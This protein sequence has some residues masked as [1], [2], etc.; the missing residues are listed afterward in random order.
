MMN[1]EMD[2]EKLEDLQK[3]NGAISELS[4]II[5]EQKKR[6]ESGSAILGVAVL[7]ILAKAR[8]SLIGIR[9]LIEQKEQFLADI[10][11][12]VTDKIRQNSSLLSYINQKQARQTRYYGYIGIVGTLLS[13]L[14]LSFYFYESLFSVF[15]VKDTV[16]LNNISN[17]SGKCVETKI[18]SAN[19]IKERNIVILE[20]ECFNYSDYKI[21]G[22]SVRYD[23]VSDRYIEIN[24]IPPIQSEREAVVEIFPYLVI[25]KNDKFGAPG[26]QF[27]KNMYS[28]NGGVLT[29]WNTDRFAIKNYPKNHIYDMGVSLIEKPFYI[30]DL[31]AYHLW[32]ESVK[33]EE[34]K[35]I[36]FKTE[37]REGYL[38]IRGYGI[39]LPVYKC[40]NKNAFST[41]P[42]VSLNGDELGIFELGSSL[43]D[44]LQC[45]DGDLGSKFPFEYIFRVSYKDSN[46]LIFSRGVFTSENVEHFVVSDVRLLY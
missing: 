43:P 42:S 41:L 1:N 5:D 32:D 45:K 10:I 46:E 28:K 38:Y 35:F 3:I 9:P 37:A 27:S 2:S 12:P 17:N 16:S 29:Q 4:N 24:T 21:G 8:D 34:S 13:F 40:K 33:G 31:N 30:G 26:I 15:Y 44:V 20:G 23:Y 19:Y 36:K 22:V 6:E 18:K 11:E 25:N 7:N 14:S 39:D